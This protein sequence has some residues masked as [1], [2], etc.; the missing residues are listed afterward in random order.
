MYKKVKNPWLGKEGYN[1]MGCAPHNPI[2]LHM[3]F[4]AA[5]DETLWGEWTPGDN[6]QGWIGVLH[7][8]IQ[9]MLLDEAAQWWINVFRGTAG[10]TSRME[11]KYR[12]SVYIKDGP[13]RVKTTFVKDL[14]RFIVMHAEL[15]NGSD[16]VCCE[17]EITYC[18]FPKDQA[19]AELGF[20]GC[21]L[22]EE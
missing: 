8:G 12:K 22:E 1:C 6:Y 14:R 9:A 5:E 17:A 19:L 11:L 15:L 21:E 2:G 3:H 18:Q 10:V 13:L 7:G 4:Y 20:S 16:E